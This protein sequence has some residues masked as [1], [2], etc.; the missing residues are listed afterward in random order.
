MSDPVQL[1]AGIQ[2]LAEACPDTAADK[3]DLLRAA[4]GEGFQSIDRR[5]QELGPLQP[6]R[7]SLEEAN[8]R[9]S[10]WAKGLRWSS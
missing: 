3:W 9:L 10:A 8:V 4:L 1:E 5:L 6:E 2:M 7:F